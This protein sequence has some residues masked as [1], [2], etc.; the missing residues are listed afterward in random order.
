M[1]SVL[2]INHSLRNESSIDVKAQRRDDLLILEVVSVG[3]YFHLDLYLSFL[4][5]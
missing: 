2:T 1:I 3:N 5:L 4:Y